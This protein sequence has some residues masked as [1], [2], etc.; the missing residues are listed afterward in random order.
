MK[1]RSDTYYTIVIEDTKLKRIIAAGTILV[2]RKFVHM[3]GLVVLTLW[4]CGIEPVGGAYRRHCHSQRLPGSQPR[5]TVSLPF[6][7]LPP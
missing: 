6:W 2:E 7:S 3:N 4:C 1:T 5:K